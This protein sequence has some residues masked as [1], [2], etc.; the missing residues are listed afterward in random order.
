MKKRIRIPQQQ[1]ALPPGTKF[2]RLTRSRNND[3]WIIWINA[4]PDFEY[5]TFLYLYNNGRIENWTTRPDQQETCFE[6]RPPD[7]VVE[8]EDDKLTW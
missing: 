1:I 2:L 5:G 8:N 3:G 7:A 6:V 4:D